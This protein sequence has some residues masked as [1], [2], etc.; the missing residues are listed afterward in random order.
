[1]NE[2]DAFMASL[3]II[4]VIGQVGVPGISAHAQDIAQSGAPLYDHFVS[5]D[6]TTCSQMPV[7]HQT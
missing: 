1:M 7:N 4:D 3:K 2:V 5:A 6:I